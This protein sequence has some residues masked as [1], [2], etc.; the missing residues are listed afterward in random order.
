MKKLQVITDKSNRGN[1]NFSANKLNETYLLNN[2]AKI[3]QALIDDQIKQMYRNTLPCIH[4]FSFEAVKEIDIIKAVNSIKTLSEG[5][6][7]INV[8]ILKL[9]INRISGVLTHIIN[10]SL[11]KNSFRK[12][13]NMALL[14][15]FLN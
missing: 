6:D 1:F 5:V 13:G 2:N 4:K 8:F 12:G 3:D 10:T 9:L 11:K 15:L 14:L 7:N